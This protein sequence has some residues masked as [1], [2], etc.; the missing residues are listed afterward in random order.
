MIKI[1]H[2][3]QK[4]ENKNILPENPNVSVKNGR[5][6]VVVNASNHMSVIQ[7]DIPNSFSLSGKISEITRNGSDKMAHDAIK[8]ASEKL[9]NGI[10][11][12]ASTQ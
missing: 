2:T 3:T 6:F 8:I 5:N 11:L 4:P 12:N 7:N 1:M 10:Q 9:A